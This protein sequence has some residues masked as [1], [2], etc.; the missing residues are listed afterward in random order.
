MLLHI[1]N[2]FAGMRAFYEAIVS[3]ILVND[4]ICIKHPFDEDS[5]GTLL[6]AKKISHPLEGW[7]GG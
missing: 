6:G 3:A 2:F 7:T 1:P 4:Q 5:S